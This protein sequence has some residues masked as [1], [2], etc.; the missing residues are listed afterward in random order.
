LQKKFQFRE[1]QNAILD[2]LIG[3]LNE[4]WNKNLDSLSGLQRMLFERHYVEGESVGSLSNKFAISQSK[5]RRYLSRGVFILRKKFNP[6]YF[7][8][9][10]KILTEKSANHVSF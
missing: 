4:N 3:C 6:G 10:E 5:I 7:E 2:K 9:A 8:E 1:E